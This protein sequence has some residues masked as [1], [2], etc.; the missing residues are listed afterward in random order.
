MYT[1]PVMLR[2]GVLQVR[3]GNGSWRDLELSDYGSTTDMSKDLASLNRISEYSADFQL[4]IDQQGLVDV[5]ATAGAVVALLPPVASV[6]RGTWFQIKKTDSGA[7]DVTITGSAAENIDGSNTY[8]LD[9]QYDTILVQSNKDQTEWLVTAAEVAS[10]DHAHSN[11]A[12]LDAMTASFLAQDETDID[13]LKVSIIELT[14][15]NDI[16][17][18][19]MAMTDGAGGMDLGAE[20]GGIFLGVNNT[21]AQIAGAA[22]GRIVRNGLATILAGQ[23]DLAAEAQIVMGPLGFAVDFKVADVPLMSGVSGGAND[24]FTAGVMSG[25]EAVRIVST[26]GGDTTQTVKIFGIAGGVIVTET[27]TANGTSTVDSSRTDWTEILAIEI[28]VGAFSGNLTLSDAV[29]N[30]IKTLTTPATG[31][32][33]AVATDDS[34]DSDGHSVE[35]KPTGANTGV[36]GVRGTGGDDAEK[37]ELVTMAGAGVGVFNLTGFKTI[38]ELLIGTD[39]IATETYDVTIKANDRPLGVTLAAILDG[40]SGSVVLY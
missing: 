30:G 3:D 25:A 13:F 31:F 10:T 22:A 35:I 5:D 33:G 28:G 29:D 36:I 32:Y 20:Q 21:G 18:D 27:L 11:K 7:N 4:S 2:N 26:V 16:E 34:D 12:I 39:G 1:T 19:E 15:A 23:D 38:T 14:A 9:V 24:D 40:A 8:I 37:F 6:P 17:D